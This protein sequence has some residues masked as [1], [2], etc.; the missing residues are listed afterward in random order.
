MTSGDNAFERRGD[1]EIRHTLREEFFRLVE[2]LD[3]R[4][5]LCFA[6]GRDGKRAFRVGEFARIC[7]ARRGRSSQKV[8]VTL[9]TPALGFA[10]RDRR[11]REC[12]V[13]VERRLF[14]LQSRTVE[15]CEFVAC[16]NA[17]TDPHRDFA[18]D[19]WFLGG[20]SGA[21]TWTEFAKDLLPRSMHLSNWHRDTY[22]RRRRA[23][24]RGVRGCGFGLALP[25]VCNWHGN[26][27]RRQ[28]DRE[29]ERE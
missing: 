14:K 22:W 2:H 13:R 16:A 27:R 21:L 9:G 10:F 7:A 12:D 3:R 15:H 28:R 11:L 26:E 6:R 25:R 17:I 18:H 29:C 24:W 5:R 1:G 8:E 4:Q 19:A 23:L 20:N